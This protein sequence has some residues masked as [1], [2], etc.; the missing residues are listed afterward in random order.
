VWLREF[1]YNTFLDIGGSPIVQTSAP[2]APGDIRVSAPIP[3]N[4]L[5][6]NDEHSYGLLLQLFNGAG[7]PFS[8]GLY[9]VVIEYYWPEFF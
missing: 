6:R 9:K 7:G 2:A 4:H 5:V 3:G 8:V 1:R